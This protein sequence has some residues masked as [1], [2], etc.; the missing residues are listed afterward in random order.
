MWIIYHFYVSYN[1]YQ[2]KYSLVNI[3]SHWLHWYGFSPLCT[4]QIFTWKCIITL[5]TLIWILWIIYPIMHVK[6]LFTWK[7]IFILNI[8][9]GLSPFSEFI[10]LTK[11]VFFCKFRITFFKLICTFTSMHFNVIIQNVLFL[12]RLDT[13][14]CIE[15]SFSLYAVINVHQD[16]FFS[17]TTQDTLRYINRTSYNVTARWIEIFYSLYRIF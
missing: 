12:K 8:Y 1:E 16:Y 11:Y 14:I 7:C 17:L 4:L 13:N 10:C 3:F 2:K 6:F 15:K 5:N 9:Y